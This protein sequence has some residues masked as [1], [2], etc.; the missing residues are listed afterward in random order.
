MATETMTDGMGGKRQPDTSKTT[1]DFDARLRKA[2]A[3]NAE[4]TGTAAGPRKGAAL[5]IAFRIAA[6]LVAA[7]AVGAGI[8]W[9]LDRWLDT[10]PWFL[11]VFFLLGA[12][13]G[14]MNVIRVAN[15]AER[16][17][18]AGRETGGA[19]EAP[20]DRP[21]GQDQ[22]TAPDTG[23]HPVTPAA[24]RQ[25]RRPAAGRQGGIHPAGAPPDL[26][27]GPHAGTSFGD[28]GRRRRSAEGSTE[29]TGH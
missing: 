7:I 21:P 23:R 27:R 6:D 18:R 19:S 5:G 3:A 17:A 9:A 20:T 16:A 13:A 28:D 10:R 1:D 12:A 29:G 4:K 26:I 2:Q 11:L 24:D 15:E 22:T 8:G 25:K 14:V